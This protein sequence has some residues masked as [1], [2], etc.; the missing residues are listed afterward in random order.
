MPKKTAQKSKSTSI[1]SETPKRLA[2]IDVLR[3]CAIWAMFAYHFSFDLNYFG[4]VHQNFNE[5]LFWLTCRAIILSSFLF[6]VG[7]SLALATQTTLQWKTLLIRIGKV[8]LCA[9]L[10]SVGSFL[11]FPES[12]I[13]F[14]V[15][16]HI[17]LASFLGLLFLRLGVLNLILGIT[18]I[19]LG[20]ALKIPVFD[21]S[22]LQ[23]IGFMTH[24][25]ITE[26]YVPVFPWFGV[27]LLGIYTGNKTIKGAFPKLK[28]WKTQNKFSRALEFSG[29]HSLLLYMIHQPVFIGIFFLLSKSF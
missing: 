28:S 7:L 24:K 2:F 11:I 13:F 3:G 8:I 16:H 19:L 23:W 1:K 26:D 15:L 6:L 18:I 29:R 27:V 25:P 4:W 14:G 21:M 17:A 10:V 12:W 22:A 5:E 9:A 20:I